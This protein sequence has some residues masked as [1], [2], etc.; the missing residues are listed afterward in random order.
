MRN[1]PA[2]PHL[3]KLDAVSQSFWV[4]SPLGSLPGSLQMH[5]CGSRTP[6]RSDPRCG[7]TFLTWLACRPVFSPSSAQ[8]GFG[9]EDNSLCFCCQSNLKGL[10]LPQDATSYELMLCGGGQVK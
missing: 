1:Q 9:C 8:D 6:H 5:T 10:Q 2:T 7:S 3:C 4:T